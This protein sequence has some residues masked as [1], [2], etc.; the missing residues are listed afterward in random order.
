MSDKATT[1]A[2]YQATAE[3]YALRV[4]DLAPVESINRFA[5]FLSRPAT[6]LDIGCGSGRD[7]AI[8]LEKGLHV[9]GIDFCPALIDI[10]RRTAP[11]G[12]FHIMEMEKITLPNEAYDGVWAAASLLHLH[13]AALPP[14]LHR[15]HTLLKPN[16]YL[17]LTLKQ[18]DGEGLETDLRY[19][20]YKKFWALYQPEELRQLLEN[21]RF[22]ILE[23]VTVEKK[24][25]YHTHPSLRAFCRKLHQ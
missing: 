9:V 17:Y 20:D 3:A 13:K 22:S 1:L 24:V 4:A 12:L 7:A 25:E 14:V 10:A 2:S 6:I 5:Q 19:G 18:G 15:I 21:A 23:L 8:F 16:G 11:K